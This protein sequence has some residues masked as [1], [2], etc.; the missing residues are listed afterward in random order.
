MLME[1]G[2]EHIT[3]NFPVNVA[4]DDEFRHHRGTVT[5]RYGPDKKVGP[6]QGSHEFAIHCLITVSL[7]C[8]H[9]VKND[10]LMIA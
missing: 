3:N 4:I 10:C 2:S 7:V 8:P 5:I 9:L 6:C 1:L